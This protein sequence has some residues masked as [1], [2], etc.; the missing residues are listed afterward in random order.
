M[1]GTFSVPARRERRD[2]LHETVAEATCLCGHRARPRLAGHASCVLKS[3]ADHRQCG[4]HRGDLSCCLDG[5]GV[6][7]DIGFGCDFAYFLDRLEDSGFVVRHHDSD[8]AGVGAEGAAY[9]VRICHAASVYW[10]VGD[11]DAG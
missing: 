2:G 6:E 9:I 4:I 1:P 8:Q 5:I 11:F 7:V 10:N 3:K